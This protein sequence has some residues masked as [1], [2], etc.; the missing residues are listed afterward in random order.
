MSLYTNFNPQ[1]SMEMNTRRVAGVNMR[2]SRGVTRL[3]SYLRIETIPHFFST[4]PRS[5]AELNYQPST[6]PRD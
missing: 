1:M 6:N 2:A 4:N 3:P 5:G